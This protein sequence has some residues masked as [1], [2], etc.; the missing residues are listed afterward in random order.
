MLLLKLIV[1]MVSASGVTAKR[2]EPEDARGPFRYT[3]REPSRCASLQITFPD[4]WLRTWRRGY[5]AE[6]QT[7]SNFDPSISLGTRG[8]SFPVC[9]GESGRGRKSYKASPGLLRRAIALLF[10]SIVVIHTNFWQVE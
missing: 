7:A 9:L 6:L 1:F 4:A 3:F 8:R 2:G 10:L 5:K